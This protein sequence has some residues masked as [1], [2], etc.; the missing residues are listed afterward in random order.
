[1]SWAISS[2]DGDDR[3]YEDDEHDDDHELLLLE[4]R[5]RREIEKR[6]NLPSCGYNNCLAELI[7]SMVGKKI[8]FKLFGGAAYVHHKCHNKS[9]E[10]NPISPCN[11]RDVDIYLYDEEKNRSDL[12]LVLTDFKERFAFPSIEERNVQF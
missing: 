4:E 3:W 10:N 12:G 7:N 8:R 6:A 2:G 11:T 5:R 9:D 1:M